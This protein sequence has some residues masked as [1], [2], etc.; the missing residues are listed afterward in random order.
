L[1]RRSGHLLA[2]ILPPVIGDAVGE[3]GEHPGRV[4]VTGGSGFIGSHTIEP[5]LAAGY[6]VHVIGRRP[7][8]RDD[9][10]WH[11]IDLFDRPGTASLVREIAPTHLL[12]LAWYAEHG[13]FWEAPENLAWVGATLE[14]LR[15]FLD[16]GG[17]RAVLAGTCAEYD[18]SETDAPV[19]ERIA[20][21]GPGT[22]ELPGTLYGTAKHAAHLVAE[23]YA[24]GEGASFA[25]GRVFLLYGPGEDE[26]RLMPAV[27]RALL[28]GQCARTSDGLQ[29]RDLMHVHDVAAAFVALLD[30]DVQG[31][32][33]VASGEAVELRTAIELIAQASGSPELLE[34]GALPR[35]EGE[36]DRLVADTA[37]L[38][39]EVGFEPSISLAAGIAETVSW[40]AQR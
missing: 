26:R 37:R 38:R 24:R 31:A 29:V 30:S 32:V 25:W 2:V 10:Q 12:H 23:R 40:W 16:A 13:R 5:L 33:N 36:P 9:I 14:L 18:W 21:G 7:V 15:D 39:R 27:A 4:L 3:P 6:E 17:R 35:R 34:L 28:S 22:P 1:A 11:S 8:L 20:P 19:R